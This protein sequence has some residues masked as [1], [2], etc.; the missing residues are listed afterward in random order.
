VARASAVVASGVLSLMGLAGVHAQEPDAPAR[1]EARAVE[2]DEV[3]A[4]EVTGEET[5]PEE[6][7]GGV[8]AG[9]EI[10]NRGLEVSSEVIVVTGSRIGVDPMDKP[11]PVLELGKEEIARSGL[12]SV[13]DLLQRLP[14]SGGAINSR[15]NASGNSGFPPDGGGVGAGAAE[16]D[17][18]YLGSKRVLVLVDG[19]RW[20]NGSSAS[21]VPSAT[22]LNTIPAAMIERV[23]VLQDGASP[24]YGSDAIGG[25]INIITRKNLDGAVAS[26]YVGGYDQGDGLTQEY[27]LAWGTQT[28]RLQLTAGLSFVDQGRVSSGDRE[29]SR[30][31]IPGVPYCTSECSSATPQGRFSFV[32][33]GS[34]ERVNLAL[35]PQTGRPMYNTVAPGTD[36]DY[37]P[38]GNA[39]RF[40]FAP[41]NLMMTP[42]RRVGVFGNLNYRLGSGLFAHARA[43][44][45]RRESVNQAAPE[46][47]FFGPDAGTGT[48]M[49]S[50]LIHASNP[51]NPFGFTFDPATNPYFIGRRAVEA[52]PRIFEQEVNTLYLLGG[53]HGR[54]ELGKAGFYWD[55]S[56][57]YS[58]NRADQEKTGGFNSEHLQLALGPVEECEATPGC[59][60]FN[61][62]GGQGA[63][64]RGTITQEMLDYAGF[65]QRDR[66]EQ[67]LVD[68]TANLGAD[69]LRLPS[70][71]LSMAVG[72]EHRRQE[73][74]FA[75]DPVV[76]A[77]NSTDVPA[78]PTSGEFSAN[79]A[80]AEMRIPLLARLPGANLLDVAGAVRV[81]D[82]ST[83]GSEYTFRTG[84][85]WRLDP[86][87]M[88]RGSYAQGFR[89][90]GIGELFGAK[91]QYDQEIDDPCSDMLGIHGGAA[92]SQETVDN[93][94]ARG[95]PADGSYE[96][97]N[98]QIS[99]NTGGNRELEPETSETYTV[100]L[101]YS[102]GWARRRRFSENL[103]VELTF[104]RIELDN[105]IAAVHG[106]VLMDTCIR[107][108]D[109]LACSAINRTGTGVID[110][111]DNQLTNIG[112][113]RTDGFD[114]TLSYLTPATAAGQL[115]FTNLS[116]YL[117][118]FDELV[119]TSMGFDRIE[120]AGTEVG[121]PQRAYP[122]F[123]STAIL[124][125]MRRSWRASLTA[126]YIHSVTEPCR[127]LSEFDLCSD[128]DPENDELSKNLLSA[129]LYAD[130]QV[131]W[132]PGFADGKLDVS[133]GVN[134]L[135]NQQP[136]VCYSCT[137][138]GF[139]ATTYDV[140]GVFAYVKTGYRM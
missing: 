3:E 43:L 129:T 61:L 131:G 74:F 110:R 24:I 114:L 136:P 30:H 11:A 111:L 107:T 80:Y 81:S 36:D 8:S 95:V 65:V 130:V 86:D 113:I 125:W 42:S 121:D 21:G 23:E 67:E 112:G 1:E 100:G 15:F 83:F 71:M 28:D 119:P 116:G 38:F 82:Y 32:K 98:Q 135:L 49:D 59:V 108:L 89:A 17:L 85:R 122:R 126:R 26:A 45:N 33:P 31:A 118:R 5:A 57:V 79:E 96:Q 20:V 60:P 140:P 117:L 27:N 50:I 40:N 22:D 92:A 9:A 16:A 99:V 75:P 58:V 123:K 18:R 115:R 93:C 76:S 124:D 66:S 103:A 78:Q 62:F 56:A 120:R 2:E 94:I 106:Q 55:T 127:G 102:P 51:Y 44:F 138:N 139:D 132:V 12:T 48:R 41:Y 47:L 52:G 70:G 104:Y 73:G 63:D 128:P 105:A 64:G 37:S 88:L 10:D 101:T 87:L 109:P 4:D 34:Q 137:L 13:A 68:V 54:F 90:P 46:P 84:L 133:L 19:V 25:V 72:L 91:T 14:V 39:D 35:R 53:M 97:Y 29:I 77:G 69:L 6:S 134:N 7:A